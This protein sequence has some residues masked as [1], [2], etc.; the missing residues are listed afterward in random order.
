MT[1]TSFHFIKIR[2]VDEAHF[3]NVNEPCYRGVIRGG[4]FKLPKGNG[5]ATVAFRLTV[6]ISKKVIQ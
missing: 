5:L 3:I 2:A 4:L 1:L 6:K